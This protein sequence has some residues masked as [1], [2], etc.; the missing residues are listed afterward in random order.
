M[1]MADKD[2]F[3]KINLD[4]ISSYPSSE[5]TSTEKLPMKREEPEKLSFKDIV[6]GNREVPRGIVQ[7]KPIAM[8]CIECGNVIVEVDGDN[9]RKGVAELKFS[10]VG[11]L[12]IQ[13]GEIPPTILELKSKL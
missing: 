1:T 12:F 11:R 8:S 5:K 2:G 3:S 10:V 13:K 4:R 9:Y 7:R 6:I